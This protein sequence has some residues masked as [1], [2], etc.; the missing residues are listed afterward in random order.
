[1]RTVD[2]AVVG[3]GIVGSSVALYG[4]RRN[5]E[6]VVVDREDPAAASGA[7]TGILPAPHFLREDESLR[8]DNA[9]AVLSR[10]AYDHYPGLVERLEEETG[11][12]LD[13]R[14]VGCWELAATEE[15][16]KRKRGYLR[17][18]KRHG[19]PGRWAE[20]GEI[21]GEL[22]TVTAPVTGGFFHPEQCLVDPL[23]LLKALRVAARDRGAGWYG[24]REVTTLRADGAAPPVVEVKGGEDI[25]A[26]FAVVAAGCWSRRFE[27]DLGVRIPVEPRR[28]QTVHTRWDRLSGMPVVRRGDHSVVARADG[29]V[30][31]GAT[32]EES[33]FEGTATL[34]GAQRLMDWAT[35]LMGGLSERPL[36]A[37]RSGLRPYLDRTGGPLLGA[38]PGVRGVYL[39]TGHY[40]SGILQGPFCGRLLAE[41]MAGDSPAEKW[42]VLAPPR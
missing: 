11:I 25:E 29:R 5:L 13:Y 24:E 35:R 2:V 32:V 20:P 28:G 42:E 14:R 3:G 36:G 41:A 22:P 27:E 1:M 18:M 30:V 8:E 12:D 19:T 33:G 6:V 21:A 34:G 7:A 16:R 17:E 4:A 10:R 31:L 38:V 37:V 15:E 40:R 9:H 39:A 23:R 26:R